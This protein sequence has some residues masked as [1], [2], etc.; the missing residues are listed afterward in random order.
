MFSVGGIVLSPML[1]ILAEAVLAEAALTLLGQP[2]R[3][4][5]CLAGALATLWTLVHPFLT[6]GILAGS[7]IITIYTRTLEN[8]ARVL[9]LSPSAVLLVLAALV[10]LHA[11]LGAAG[12]LL[13]WDA[14][15][16]AQSRL[17]PAAAVTAAPSSGGPGEAKGP[18]QL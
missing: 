2:R 7:G 17:R 11:A 10:G 14:G 12:G 16:V 8:G 9:G 3:F 15:R 6:Q 13:A 1:G 4:S 18:R 5:F